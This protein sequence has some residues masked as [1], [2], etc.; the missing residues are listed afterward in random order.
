MVN[1]KKCRHTRI[2]INFAKSL[3][4]NATVLLCTSFPAEIKVDAARNIL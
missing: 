1:Q 4:K 3:P 2:N